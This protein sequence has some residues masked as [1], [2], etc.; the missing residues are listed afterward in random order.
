MGKL[1]DPKYLEF[2]R[3]YY[4]SIW[5]LSEAIAE[6]DEAVI[7]IFNKIA[8]PEY[9]VQNEYQGWL[10]KFHEEQRIRKENKERARAT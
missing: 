7:P 8:S 5:R 10:Y 4:R 1:D 3:E 2:L 9:F 6:K